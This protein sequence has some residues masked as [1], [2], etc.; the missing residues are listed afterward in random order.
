M[1][2]KRIQIAPLVSRAAD[3]KHMRNGSSTLHTSIR[4]NAVNEPFKGL[5]ERRSSDTR[6]FSQVKGTIVSCCGD[7]WIQRGGRPC[8]FSARAATWL[9][10]VLVRAQAGKPTFRTA[11][12]GLTWLIGAR[13]R[14][15]GRRV[16]ARCNCLQGRLGNLGRG[17]LHVSDW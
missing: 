13:S 2:A 17:F 10:G 4:A 9:P 1:S 12:G 5:H 8:A 6:A 15:S 16:P 7:A 14:R 11:S 3:W